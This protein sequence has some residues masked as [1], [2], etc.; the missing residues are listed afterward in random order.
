[1]IGWFGDGNGYVGN[2]ELKP[3]VAHTVSL[4]GELHDAERKDWSVSATPYYTYAHNYINVDY[5][6]VNS[7]PGNS[8]NVLRFANHDAQLYG[9]DLSGYTALA[10]DATLGHF[11]VT[12]I[13]GFVRGNQINNGNSLYHMMPLN[14]KMTLDHKLGGWSNAIDLRMVGSKSEAD[15]L[16]QEPFTPG[17]AIVNMRT[18]YDWQ[19]VRLDAGIDNLFD[20]QYYDPL[21]GA[22]VGN[23]YANRTTANGGAYGPLASMG[24]SYNA[25]V[26][27]KF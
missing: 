21:G 17:F 18:A 6:G 15:P 5:V 14:L 19:N 16:R 2:T 3:E 26:T 8:P 22:A 13:A 25:G 24:R 20:H 23:Y 10:D 4:T 9:T 7:Y 11:G 27:V 1:M 12:G